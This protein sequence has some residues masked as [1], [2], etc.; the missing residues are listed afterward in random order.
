MRQFLAWALGAL[1]LACGL[2]FAQPGTGQISGLVYSSNQDIVPGATIRL[3]G[4]TPAL[5]RVHQTATTDQFGAFNFSALPAGRYSLSSAFQGQGFSAQI[6]VVT[7]AQ[8]VTADM[9]LI[10]PVA[11][12][13]T[14]VELHGTVMV[15]PGSE[16]HPLPAYF[17]SV[18]GSGGHDYRLCFGPSWYNPEGIARPQN[19]AEI[20][21]QAELFSYG[22]LSDNTPPMLI[23]YELSGLTWRN[24]LYGYG[25][26]AGHRSFSLRHCSGS[27]DTSGS[28]L[29]QVLPRKEYNGMLM[30]TDCEPQI[31]NP[32]GVFMYRA[33]G[34]TFDTFITHNLNL[35]T[36]YSGLPG[37][38]GSWD[39]YVVGGLI[40]AA[41]TGQTPWLIVY[42]D[43]GEFVREPGDTTF[44]DPMSSGISEP[45]RVG[46]P[47]SYLTASNYPNPFNPATTISYSVPVAG[48]V[49]L[50]VYD[51]TGREVAK[52]VNGTQTAGRYAAT[53]D[54]TNL[55]SGIYFY[56]LTS[57]MQSFTNRM[58][59]L[60]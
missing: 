30:I 5:P 26:S 53:F 60:K 49:T 11:S 1:F 27:S 43:N 57:G 55:A 47:T 16:Q 41:A 14:Q 12:T 8:T 3:D 40:P 18:D 38:G 51:L 58:V 50:S 21:V 35:G 39:L 2:A 29:P 7:D 46:E 59:L 9:T 10:R 15:V 19:G 32:P 13:L 22:K 48:K 52:L 23:V 24:S 54:G 20:R 34:D 37:G 45:I 56:R 28:A 6:I 44:L 31:P 25:E 33:D 42:E 4:L 36:Q 17:L